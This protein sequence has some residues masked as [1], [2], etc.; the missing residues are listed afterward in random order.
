[1]NAPV[2]A[3]RPYTAV[4]T[5]AIALF[6][7]LLVTAALGIVAV[8]N[9]RSY[10]E[11]ASMAE[12]GQLKMES[13]SYYFDVLQDAESSQRGYLIT[14]KRS[15]LEP[16]YAA[17][18]VVNARLGI[19]KGLF[20]D[21]PRAQDDMQLLETLTKQKFQE[22]K[23]TIEVHDSLGAD[24]ARA[25]VNNDLGKQTME[26]IRVA[27]LALQALERGSLGTHSSNAFTRLSR[28][29]IL[30]ATFTIITM[31]LLIVA[32][33]EIIREMRLRNQLEAQL[34]EL[35][36][37]DPLTELPNRRALN[38]LI[39]YNI[40]L[41]RRTH[42]NF[43]VMYLDLDGFK[44]LNDRWGHATGDNILRE[45]AKILKETSRES[46]TVARVGGD[47]FVV[48]IP[49]LSVAG[50]VAMLASRLL[51]AMSPVHM[52]MA[53]DKVIGASIGIAI[54]PDDG[55][56]ADALLRSAD[57]ALYR[58]KQAGKHRYQFFNDFHASST[59]TK[60]KLRDEL[61]Y[62]LE[63]NEISLVYQPIIALDKGQITGVEALLRWQHPKLGDISPEEFIPV[64]EA[65]GLM[66]P[67]GEWVL[68]QACKQ[69]KLWR[70][71]GWP[72]L[73][74]AVNITAQ[75]WRNGE[76]PRLVQ[77]TLLMHQL[78]PSALLLE[79]TERGL[80]QEPIVDEL[81]RLKRS[82]VGL[83]LDDFG[84]GYSSL[85]Y[86]KRFPI[87]YIKIDST[88]VKGLPLD[89]TDAAVVSAVIAMARRLGFGVIAEGVETAEQREFL[90]KHGC[91]YAQGYFYSKP[92]PA[93]EM[94]K[95]MRLN[96]PA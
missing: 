23:F 42:R 94:I 15:Y 3:P 56:T 20:K 49:E 57:K 26:D 29:T 92:L 19:V 8:W 53:Q 35:A 66:V 55:A 41:A 88:F 77:N 79:I 58:A 9:A 33:I 54:F 83:V 82:G 28:W 73:R 46:D 7:A 21:D 25:A 12:L 86:L 52:A 68:S 74:V 32:A 6:I 18:E 51:D 11:S 75:Q 4:R 1:V 78:P 65:S 81:K 22:M 50:E 90:I 43:A 14:S 38:E 72:E 91:D 70:S 80:T 34:R 89:E 67:L 24:A 5:T 39:E 60:P 85:N 27:V 31:L 59:V 61:E 44:A 47:E 40:S 36:S 63:R 93:L 84:T 48:L 37:T 69:V 87:D 76:L 2:L 30:G 64:A 71:E 17:S 96:I 45:V 16:Y 13:L 62:A 95:Q 10:L